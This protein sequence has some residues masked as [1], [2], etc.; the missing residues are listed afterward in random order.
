MERATALLLDIVGGQ[1]GPIIESVAA[2]ALPARS[3]ILLRRSRIQR[4]LGFLPADEQV[5]DI[6]TRLG[7][8]LGDHPEGWLAVPPSFRFDLALEADLVEE[9]GRVFGYD[10]LPTANNR[11][12]LLMRPAPETITSL[13]RIRSLLVDRGYQEAITYSFVDADV[14]TVIEPQLDSVA[15]R[16]PISSDL[17][18]M[19][20]SLWAGLI[21]AVRHN[22]ARQQGRV[23]LFESGL[24][25]INQHNEIK[26]INYV[27]GI[28]AGDLLPEQWG[29]EKR[30]V[31]FFD[32][33]GDVEALL[34]RCGVDAL[35]KAEVHPALHPGQSAAIRFQGRV[36]GWLG[37]IH[38]A[39]AARFEIPKQ[40]VLFELDTDVLH[41]GRL[42]SFQ[43]LSRFPSIRRDLSVVV[44]AETPAGALCE[45]IAAEAGA[46]LQGLTVFD[47]YQG[48]GIES[49]R[50]SIAFGLILQDSSRT[51]TDVDV[52]AVVTRVTAQLEKQF[53]ATLRE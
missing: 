35:F 19:R 6:L 33:K 49:G 26:Q 12:D 28:A 38:P 20:T 41:Q 2:D 45:A 40:T 52:E 36:I 13:E 50:K 22:L 11:G 31:D 47:V 44:S 10:N 37:C 16:N 7:L 34:D 27:S 4:L 39:L 8:T 21:A 9:V 51:L 23:R 24:K 3:K 5:A 18:V 25:F 14:A 32:V 29:D 46:I 1:A 53:G 30:S 17:S 43:N 48:K 15:L 42:P